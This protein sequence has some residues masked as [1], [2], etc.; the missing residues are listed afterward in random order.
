MRPDTKQSMYCQLLGGLVQ[1]DEVVSVGAVFASVLVQVIHFLGNYW[2]ELASN[3][4]CGNVSEW[5]TDLGCRDSISILL[6]DPNAELADQIENVCGKKSW[7]GIISRLWPNAKC[8]HTIVTGTMAQYIPALEFYSNSELPL[9]SKVY[10]SSEAFFGINLEPLRKPQHVSYTIIYST[11][12]LPLDNKV[13]V[14]CCCVKMV[15]QK[16]S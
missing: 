16:P 1:R 9:V 4:R 13:L 15:Y 5:I 12:V 8:I 7:Q 14:E 11:D 2:K 6:E 3:I 10:A